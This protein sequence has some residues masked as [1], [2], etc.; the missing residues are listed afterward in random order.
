ME[1]RVERVP[2]RLTKDEKEILQSA[3]SKFGVPLSTYIRV[4]AL[5]ASRDDG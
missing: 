3:A 4:K 5:E 2:V 1:M